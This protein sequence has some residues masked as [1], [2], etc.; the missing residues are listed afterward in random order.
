MTL[1]LSDI[2]E[3]M[4]N[5]FKQKVPKT[6]CKLREMITLYETGIKKIH[7]KSSPKGQLMEVLS[8]DTNGIAS[9]GL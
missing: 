7:N 9:S 8:T 3:L 1:E 2:Y 4:S 6:H 5:V